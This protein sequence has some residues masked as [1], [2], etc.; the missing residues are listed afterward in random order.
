MKR[1]RCL[2]L[3]LACGAA[4][5]IV[6]AAQSKPKPEARTAY[7]WGMEYLRQGNMSSALRAFNQ[8]ITFDQDYVDAIAQLA[9]T[10][11]AMPTGGGGRG[12]RFGGAADGGAAADARILANSI[13]QS[14]RNLYTLQAGLFP[15]KAIYQWALGQLDVSQTQENAESY[16]R[17]A[18]ALDAGFTR[19]ILSLA[20]TLAYRGD[21][22]GAQESSARRANLSR[23]TRTCWLPM[24]IMSA[25]PIPISGVK[26]TDRLLE[27][28]AGAR[29]RCGITIQNFGR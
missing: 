17:K 24:H 5:S 20:S 11:K 28:V 14:T 21:L 4:F 16:Y 13:L 26:L 22:A 7:E 6:G 10:A 1:C 3:A 2:I 15:N 12:A 27:S 23:R 19:A 29:G 18:V 25:I 8:A 9:S